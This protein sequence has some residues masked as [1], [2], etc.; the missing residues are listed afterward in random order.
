MEVMELATAQTAN[1]MEVMELTAAQTA[2]DVNDAKP[3]W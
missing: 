2:Q 1:R 3:H